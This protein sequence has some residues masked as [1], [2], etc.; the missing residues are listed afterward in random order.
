MW[1]LYL[2]NVEMR[3]VEGAGPHW[4]VGPLLASARMGWAEASHLPA[5]ALN[6]PGICQF[7]GTTALFRYV[8]R[9]PKK[10]VN[11]L[12]NSQKKANISRSLC[13]KG[14]QLTK[15]TPSPVV[16][17][18]TNIRNGFNAGLAFSHFNVAVFFLT[19]NDC[20]RDFFMQPE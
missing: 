12:Q 6:I 2:Q 20:H 9:A 19:C 11:L 16:G 8:K 5:P 14:H 18:G 3:A 10:C 17:V 15:S 7:L 1:W 4:L 13:K